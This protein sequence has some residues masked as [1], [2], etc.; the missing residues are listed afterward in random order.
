MNGPGFELADGIREADDVDLVD[1]TRDGYQTI[2]VDAHTA[3]AKETVS[4]LADQYDFEVTVLEDK[5]DGEL[6][7]W[8][9]KVLSPQKVRMGGNRL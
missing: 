9:L 2:F 4:E 3:E 8:R 5:G 1:F 7:A 6:A